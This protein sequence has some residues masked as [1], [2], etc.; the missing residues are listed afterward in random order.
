[1]RTTQ[2]QK[3]AKE[4]IEK[5]VSDGKIHPVLVKVKMS[6]YLK[7]PE[8]VKEELGLLEAQPNNVQLTK[9]TTE[10]NTK[11]KLSK[12]DKLAMK[13]SGLNPEDPKDVKTYQDAQETYTPKE[14][15]E[16]DE[17]END[18]EGGE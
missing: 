8:S 15:D 18:N 7:D 10:P 9:T 12:S 16:D 4:Y 2:L 1:L 5:A 11:I 17:D 3:E 14:I 6:Q 13:G